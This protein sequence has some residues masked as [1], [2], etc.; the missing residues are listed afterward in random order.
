MPEKS[1]INYFGEL[2][3]ALMKFIKFARCRRTVK[4]A[5]A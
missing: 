5:S 3:A 4:S 1:G 2:Y